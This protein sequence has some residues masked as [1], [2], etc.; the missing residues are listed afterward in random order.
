MAIKVSITNSKVG[1]KVSLLNGTS[2]RGQD[3]D[4]IINID[5]LETRKK[6]EMLNDAD[7]SL[8]LSQAE[9]KSDCDS[10]EYESLKEI[11]DKKPAD[12]R[13]LMD[14]IFNHLASFTTGTLANI[15]AAYIMK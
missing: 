12:K 6:I 11:N 14:A 8:I 15:L 10:P 13:K 2:I 1:G 9:S 7:I 3:D 5:N 4:I